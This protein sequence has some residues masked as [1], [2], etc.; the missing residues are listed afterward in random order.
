[1]YKFAKIFN[2]HNAA[3][4]VASFFIEFAN[5]IYFIEKVSIINVKIVPDKQQ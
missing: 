1:M 3:N 5:L 4:I 2:N